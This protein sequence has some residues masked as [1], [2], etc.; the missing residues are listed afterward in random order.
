MMVVQTSRSK[1]CCGPRHLSPEAEDDRW[2]LV[3]TALL[4]LSVKI[5]SLMQMPCSQ[6]WTDNPLRSSGAGSDAGLTA[7]EDTS[8]AAAAFGGAGALK[9]TPLLSAAQSDLRVIEELEY[10]RLPDAEEAPR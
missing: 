4:Y 10:E 6:S 9:H 1:G 7:G 3:C 8:E 2:G 5:V